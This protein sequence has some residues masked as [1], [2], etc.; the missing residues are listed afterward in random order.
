[1]S[2][3]SNDLAKYDNDDRFRE[4]RDAIAAFARGEFLLVSDDE[5]RENE[6]DLIIAAEHATPAAVNFMITE[7]KGL[8]CICVT[9]ELAKR[10]GLVPMVAANQCQRGTAFTVSVDG[11]AEHGITTGIS[12]AER[13]KTIELIISRQHGGEALSAPGH[14]FPLVARPGGVRERQGHTEAGVELARL[15]GCK[16]AAVIVE[17]IKADGEMARRPDLEIMAKKFSIRYITI[18]ALL[19]YVE[20]L[21]RPRA[22]FKLDQQ[23][24]SASL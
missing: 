17:V 4:V 9:P 5:D 23:S 22:S 12:A 13:A 24:A 11:T 18:A 19:A 7:G 6:G 3:L 1:M 21:E 14:M 10:K 2:Q 15:A 8:V 16:P 20:H